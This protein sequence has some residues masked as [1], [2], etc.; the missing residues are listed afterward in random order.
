L[1]R[2][3]HGFGAAGGEEDAVQRVG[4]Q[5]GD[6][7]GQLDAGLVR[8]TEMAAI[9]EA[10]HLMGSDIGQFASSVANLDGEQTGESIKVP[11]SI[12][13]PKVTAFAAF[14]N[15]GTAFDERFH[16]GKMQPR[17]TAKITLQRFGPHN[18]RIGDHEY[19][20]L[21]LW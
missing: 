4:R 14:N 21:L 1:E 13:V 10:T 12:G 7:G 9:G 3:F 11:F 5:F 2:R 19:T 8:I 15:E 6:A 16:P 18:S 20:T 17:V